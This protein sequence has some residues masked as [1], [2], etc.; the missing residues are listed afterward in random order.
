MPGLSVEVVREAAAL[1]ALEPE[2]W[3]LWHA[4]PTATPFQSPAW[5]LPWWRHFP[6]AGLVV[7][8]VRDGRCLIGL[9]P[10]YRLIEHGRARILPLGAGITDYVDLVAAP[11]RAVEVAARVRTALAAEPGIAAV[12]VEPLRPGS[13][14]LACSRGD[15]RTL[16]EPAPVA[17]LDAADGPLA[18]RLRKLPYYRRRAAALG[19]TRLLT[20]GPADAAALVAALITLHATRWAARGAT[21][22]L[23]DPAVRAFHGETAPALARAGLLRLHVLAIDGRP[24][25]AFYGFAR[26]P[27]LLAYL[28]GHDSG[29]PHP[30]LGAMLLGE[31]VAAARAEGCRE[32]HLLRGAEP[33]KYA[34]GAEDR[35]LLA[36]R[37]GPT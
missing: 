23:A 16:P 11:G 10:A 15:L 3:A 22:V 8:T 32:L 25:A 5:L 18:G 4:D 37:L 26:P 35:P 20:A 34:W 24:A 7:V 28:G 33:Y 1:V 12:E 21:G 6:G 31:A 17:A 14:L 29:L 30:G 2:W 9:F 13:P 36:L 19:G 27:A